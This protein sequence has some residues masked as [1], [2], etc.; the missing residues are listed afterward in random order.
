MVK[1]GGQDSSGTADPELVER[2]R[3][4]ARA[5][6]ESNWLPDRGCCVPKPM[7]YPHRWLWDSC[8]HAIAWASLGDQRCITELRTTL[9]T[10]FRSGFVPHMAYFGPTIAR[11]PRDDASSVTQPHV[12]CHAAVVVRDL[13]FAVDDE[14]V[15]ACVRGME[16]LWA[17]RM[18]DDGLLT[19]VHPWEAGWDD[20]PRWD[21]W[22]GSSDW[23]RDHWTQVDL[24][25]IDALTFDPEGAAVGSTAF[26][27]ASTG[28]NAIAAHGAIALAQLLADDD[29]RAAE[30]ARR[31]RALADAM[32]A[33]CWDDEAGQWV[34]VVRT[35]PSTGLSAELGSAHRAPTLDGLLPALVTSDPDRAARALERLERL[36]LRPYGVTFVATD[37]PMFD[38]DLY[39][40]GTAWPPLDHYSHLL[41]QRLGRSDVA[42]RIAGA[43]VDGALA[44]G[45]AEHRNACTGEGRGHIPVTWAASAAWFVR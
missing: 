31:G 45:F 4:G 25:L 9:A 27:V 39:W 7:T 40:R 32:D 6:L 43:S 12:F 19:I 36:H 35:G 38:A 24:D 30:W 33:L 11:G 41:A 14:L 2:V 8:F 21:A 37:A 5:V 20:S 15:E 22:A 13:G 34:D 29:P 42:A 17:L 16:A 1:A 44:S 3:A 10:P 28:F 26:E 23:E 18:A